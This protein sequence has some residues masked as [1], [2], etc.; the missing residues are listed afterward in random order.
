[1]VSVYVDST[2]TIVGGLLDGRPYRGVLLGTF[3]HDVIV[4][5]ERSDIIIS[6][7]GDDVICGNGG[8]DRIITPHGHTPA[9]GRHLRPTNTDRR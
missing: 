1:M 7:M 9:H 2:E 8:F 5:T 4:G 6:F 3:G